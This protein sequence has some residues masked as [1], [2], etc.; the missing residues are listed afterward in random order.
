MCIDAYI[1]IYAHFADGYILVNILYASSCSSHIKASGLNL[2]KSSVKA[3]SEVSPF[4]P[5]QR[6]LTKKI[7]NK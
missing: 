4:N 5:P 6:G 7:I 3:G 2:T 1:Y